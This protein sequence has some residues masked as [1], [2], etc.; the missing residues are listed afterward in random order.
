MDI[1]ITR[2]MVCLIVKLTTTKYVRFCISWV[3]SS[4]GVITTTY[5]V[6][7]YYVINKYYMYV[8]RSEL[9]LHRLGSTNLFPAEL[10][11]CFEERDMSI[12]VLRGEPEASEQSRR[13]NLYS[14]ADLKFL[15]SSFHCDR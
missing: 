3:V 10:W 6:L 9:F 4:Q 7:Q 11:V 8:L 15:P 13:P 12:W 14:V 5:Y 1:Y 2:K